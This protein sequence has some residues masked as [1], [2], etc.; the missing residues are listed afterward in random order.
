VRWRTARGVLPGHDRAPVPHARK[1]ACNADRDAI[2]IMRAFHA[3]CA[4]VLIALLPCPEGVCAPAADPGASM[5]SFSGFG[6]LGLVH[7]SEDR[8]DFTANLFQPNGA[9]YTN[10]WSSDVDSLIGAQVTARFTPQLSAVLQVISEQNYNDTYTPH[11]EWANVAYQATPDLSVRAGRTVLSS[12]LFSDTRKVGYTLPWVRPP[13]D[14]YSLVPITGSDG[15]D[16]RYQLHFGDAVNT[17]VGTYGGTREN[18]PSGQS[19]A[20]RQWAVTDTLLYGPLTAYVTYHEAHL[21]VNFLN[22]FL[23][24]FRNFGPQG[25]AIADRYDEDGKLLQFFGLGAEYDPGKWFIVGEWGK[26][27]LHSA[28]GESTAWYAS[29]G[30]R[31]AKFTP[32]ITFGALKADSNRS[33]PGLNV[34]ALP[35]SLAGDASGL[36]AGLNAILGGIADQKTVSVGTRWDVVNNVDLKLQFDHTRLGPGSPGTFINIQ[37]GFTPGGTVNILSIAIDFLW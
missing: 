17:T 14:L 29:G 35:P 19:A 21:T 26:S 16:A 27:N 33:D 30:Y 7:S 34:A 2:D 31:V 12:F 25:S 1:H 3:L 5:F 37:P 9:G 24:G 23:D 10:P 22:A 8:A 18:E 13:I 28:F 15:V 11:V 32:Y 36:N 4:I 6:T 20:R